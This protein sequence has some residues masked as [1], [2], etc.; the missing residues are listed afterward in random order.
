MS[1]AVEKKIIDLNE[2]EVLDF[3]KV[4]KNGLAD[5]EAANRIL[6]YGSNS[7]K[8]YSS[9]IQYQ[10]SNL[11]GI[12]LKTIYYLM[13]MALSMAVSN[14]LI[15]NVLVFIFII[16]VIGLFKVNHKIEDKILKLLRL[17]L[18]KVRRNNKSIKLSPEDIALGDII[19]FKKGDVVPADI[20]IIEVVNDILIEDLLYSNFPDFVFK[21][22]KKKPK[23]KYLDNFIF[24][25]ERIIDGEGLGVVVQVGMLTRLGK[26]LSLE[27]IIDRP[28]SD[29]ARLKAKLSQI[30]MLT[31]LAFGVIF[32]LVDLKFLKFENYSLLNFLLSILLAGIP[33]NF[34]LDF[35][36]FRNNSESPTNETKHSLAETNILASTYENLFI[37]TKT[38][39]ITKIHLINENY[40]ANK[41]SNNKTLNKIDTMLNC[42]YFT[43][44]PDV[45]LSDDIQEKNIKLN[46]ARDFSTVQA[47]FSSINIDLKD[48]FSK[49]T[50][51]KYMSIENGVFISMVKA[52]DKILC[53]VKAPSEFLLDKSSYV[54]Q[55]N[56]PRRMNLVDL[57][58]FISFSKKSLTKNI[59]LA[60]KEFDLKIKKIKTSEILKDLTYIGQIEI[61]S[62]IKNQNL[63]AIN[64]S[65]KQDIKL[66]VFCSN[67]Y[68]S[69]IIKSLMDDH[70]K[71][72]IVPGHRIVNERSYE[73]HIRSETNLL[74]IV[75][76]NT[77]VKFEIIKQLASLDNSVISYIG[78][79]INDLPS[80][81]IA[82]NG[83]VSIQSNLANFNSDYLIKIHDTNLHSVIDTITESKKSVINI[84]KVYNSIFLSAIS[85]LLLTIIGILVLRFLNVPPALSPTTILIFM[86]VGIIMPN[87][88]LFFDKHFYQEIKSM[89][90][91][92][93]SRDSFLKL[94]LIGFIISLIGFFSYLTY[95]IRS[96][97]SPYFISTS[98]PVYL[99][100]LTTTLVTLILLMSANIIF[101]KTS[102]YK[103]DLLDRLLSNKESFFV[104]ILSLMIVFGLS[105]INPLKNYISNVNLVDLIYCLF[106]TSIFIAFKSLLA[107]GRKNS[108]KELLKLYREIFG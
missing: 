103:D 96:G 15:L 11:V 59:G 8:N 2:T 18:A 77:E 83:I 98:N 66:V 95:F 100:A 40:D 55:N 74:L 56:K 68:E 28:I 39:K 23:S 99:K 65:I 20:R 19:Y 79:N 62:I 21:S 86:T 42:L 97:I 27:Q 14:Y 82:D 64:K 102:Y 26:I 72:D 75:E 93:I 37:D 47:F 5:K 24:T 85:I 33:I 104:I 36:K 63:E 94:L 52:K 6:K 41:L 67:D 92:L 13:L 34:L 51:F 71:V 48:Y 60:Y 9:K 1:F 107:Y 7:L 78:D 4:D 70:V 61:E 73:Y 88:S 17:R 57:K 25:G 35:A 91:D 46:N 58:Y 49:Y 3:L 80:L 105:Y 10:K 30:F 45:L 81:K 16:E 89:R 29:F 43:N 87:R 12:R 44:Q 54:L 53:F 108:K 31:M 101:E 84:I 32:L 38:D 76:D 22:S 106:F 90:Y 50:E 69:Q